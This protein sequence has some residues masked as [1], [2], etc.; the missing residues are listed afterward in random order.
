MFSP[1]DRGRYRGLVDGLRHHDYFMVRADFDAYRTA[2]RRSTHCGRTRERGDGK[3]I[4]N[5]A[6]MGW[7]SAD[8]AMLEYARE[9]WDVT[10]A[11]NRVAI[12]PHPAARAGIPTEDQ[13]RRR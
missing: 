7:F 8:R 5:T 10:P 3:A 12:P 4:L 9:I 11:R 1:D 13:D 6:R 2:Q